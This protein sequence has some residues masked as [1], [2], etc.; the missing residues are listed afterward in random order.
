M[1][2]TLQTY[3]YSSNSIKTNQQNL[4]FKELMVE[5]EYRKKKGFF[6]GLMDFV[7]DV[8]DGV[9]D[10]F[11]SP[12]TTQTTSTTTK[13]PEVT[14][15]TPSVTT[16]TSTIKTTAKTPTYYSSSY[17]TPP[18]ETEEERAARLAEK[19]RRKQERIQKLRSGIDNLVEKYNK[20][21]PEPLSASALIGQCNNITD[22]KDLTKELEQKIVIVREEKVIEA[23]A[24]RLKT[25]TGKTLKKYSTKGMTPEQ[26]TDL[27]REIEKT[28]NEEVEH[29]KLMQKLEKEFR[30]GKDHYKPSRMRDSFKP[31]Q[32]QEIQ[33][34]EKYKSYKEE[35]KRLCNLYLG[36]SAIMDFNAD[37]FNE[38][39]EN[40]FK[41]AA[42]SLKEIFNIGSETRLLERIPKL[43][44]IPKVL[45]VHDQVRLANCVK[46][47]Y[48]DVTNEYVKQGF[49][50]LMNKYNTQYD[51]ISEFVSKNKIQHALHL[52]FTNN[53]MKKLKQARSNRVAL[54]TEL[55]KKY[56]KSGANLCNM[57]KKIKRNGAVDI[58]R[59]A[60][61]TFIV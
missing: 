40:Y 24:V 13:Q 19:R 56:S 21:A 33:P 52:F 57:S 58:V 39:T 28:V 43:G 10:M 31:Q 53:H 61:V 2:I 17:Y 7:S 18:R 16:T 60:I 48:D 47:D 4:S 20:I 37:C 45:R 34:Q 23:L 35:L 27:R 11:A 41:T 36:N 1:K 25:V 26:V 42:I 49:A 29:E 30:K 3:R 32:L 50:P 38:L 59:K 8:V 5:P 6:S 51:A 14:T 44:I 46:K 9:A 12:K 55:L 54:S 15:Y 22:L